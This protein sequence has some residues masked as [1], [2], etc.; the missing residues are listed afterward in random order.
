MNRMLVLIG[1]AAM[2]AAGCASDGPAQAEQAH[3]GPL[4]VAVYADK[5]PD[6][7][8]AVEWFRLV[9]DSPDMELKLVSGKDVRA[10]ALDGQDLLIM[11]G[12]SSKKEFQSLG[13]NG[14]E[15]M[16]AF[17]RNGGSY[18]GTCAGNFLLTDGKDRAR[19]IPY[20]SKGSEP[21]CFFS[22]F[23]VNEAGAKA[24]G[25]ARGRHRMRYHGG[26]FLYP[27]TNVIEGAN[28]EIW[29]TY[30][31]EACF[32]GRVDRRK[33]MYRSG[34]IVGGT[35]GKGRVF[36][37][38][39]HP[40]YFESTH[41]I[42][43]AAIRYLTGRTVSF[44]SRQRRPGDLCVGYYASVGGVRTAQTALALADTEGVDFLPI[45]DDGIREGALHHLD[46]VVVPSAIAGKTNA[47]YQ[48]FERFIGDGGRVLMVDGGNKCRGRIK[49]AVP[50]ASAEELIRE[51]KRR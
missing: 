19:V 36:V 49:G 44:R 2:A 25:I 32:R 28:F 22:D 29:G 6:G 14:V 50:C 31:A 45:N 20:V 18:L 23:E 48:V 38:A 11:P 41:Y 1:V 16:K 12:G 40:E 51:V 17:I 35:Y 39:A 13:T 10:G 33:G 43:V 3:A 9:R 27:T 24:L 37:T 21:D 30:A 47:L 7:I 26:P 8:G 42:V 15:R 5:G 4:K 46:V 34:A